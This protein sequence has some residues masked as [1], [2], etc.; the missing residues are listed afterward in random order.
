[1][2]TIRQR[3]SFLKAKFQHA[4]KLKRS[5]LFLAGRRMV[6]DLV[7]ERDDGYGDSN[8]Q[9]C[10]WKRVCEAGANL[11]RGDLIAALFERSWSERPQS[12]SS[13]WSMPSARAKLTRHS[14]VRPCRTPSWPYSFSHLIISNAQTESRDDNENRASKALCH[15]VASGSSAGERER[16]RP[17]FRLDWTNA[18][19][20]ALCKR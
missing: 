18:Y 10:C 20:E 1:M 9:T 4:C 8:I 3:Y 11:V 15:R 14:P 16:P 19:V 13:D 2:R 6:R 5:L 7:E 12:A 17:S